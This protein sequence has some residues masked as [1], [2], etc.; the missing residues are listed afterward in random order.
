MGFLRKLICGSGFCLLASIAADAAPAQFAYRIT[1]SDKLGSP[2]LSSQPAWLSSRAI[3]RRS[4]F[5]ISLDSTDRLVS[6]L[7]IDSMLRISGGVLHTTSRWLNNCVI[8][9]TDTSGLDSIR[10]RPYVRSVEWVGAFANGLH[11]RVTQS[12]PAVPTNTTASKETGTSSFYGRTWAQT[13]LVHGDILHD[14]GFR[15]GGKL[16]VVM[17]DGFQY[18]DMHTGFKDLRNSGRILET[19]NVREKKTDVYASGLHGMECLSV[20]SGYDAGN[21]VGAAPDAEIALYATEDA[22]VTDA[23]YELDNLIAGLERA[24][25]LGADVVCASIVYNIF[26]SPYY[27][28]YAKSDLD[29]FST[30]VDRAV[31]MAVA[32]GIFYVSS[33]GNEGTQTWNYLDTPGDA[34][35]S[36]TIGSVDKNGVVSAFSSPGPNASG[37]IKPDL[38][39]LGDPVAIFAPVTGYT[40]SSGTSY[41][42]PQAAGF[43]ACMLQAFPN[44]SLYQIRQAIIRSADGYSSPSGKR[45]YGVPNFRQA[46]ITLGIS[47]VNRAQALEVHPNPFGAWIDLD[48]PNNY[49]D[50]QCRMFDILGREIPV[51]ILRTGA[52]LRV[53][54]LNNLPLGTYMLQVDIDGQRFSA[55]TMHW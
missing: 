33:A 52:N 3:T 4:H 42:A 7:Y 26:F 30:I 9:M 6:P 16:I 19:Y 55:R 47:N 54:P 43:V 35:S 10:H 8:L 46:A 53:E 2:Q 24:D 15:G 51:K 31:N 1:F 36:L 40:F 29:G 13:D 5:S 21:Y 18:T 14:H 28:S 41:A 37:R 34:D 38:C 22:S 27:Y 11:Q 45:G 25:S 32:K 48:L 39:F 23:I 12:G 20:I 50:V 17:D 44:A 49:S